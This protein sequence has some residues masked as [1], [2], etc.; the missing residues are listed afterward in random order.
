MYSLHKSA[1]Q[2]ALFLIPV[3]NSKPTSQ[4]W[5]NVIQQLK[6]PRKEPKHGVPF[7]PNKSLNR[8]SN[9]CLEGCDPL[10]SSPPSHPDLPIMFLNSDLPLHQSPPSSPSWIVSR[11]RLY[12]GLTFAESSP[13]KTSWKIEVKVAFEVR[14]HDTCQVVISTVA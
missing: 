1:R 14:G 8:Q 7:H 13:T 4:K 6:E 11:M 5:L 3:R 9:Q 10:F 12:S 2:K